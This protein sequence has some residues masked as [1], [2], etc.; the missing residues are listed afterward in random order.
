MRKISKTFERRDKRGIFREH[1]NTQ[2]GWKSVNGGLMKKGMIMGNHY[3]KK[4]TAVL[5]IL[6]GSARVY[7]KNVRQK[8]SKMSTLNLRESEGCVM[9]PFETHA[10]K[11]LRDSVFLLLKSH[12]FESKSPDIYESKII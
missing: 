2:T 3:H 9:Y 1:I 6:R 8:N 11:F 4:N 10:V 7:S 12:R 5:F